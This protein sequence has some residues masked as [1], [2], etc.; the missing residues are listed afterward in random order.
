[1]KFNT[2]L[3]TPTIYF[4]NFLGIIPICLLKAKKIKSQK[5]I[6]P[7]L[8]LVLIISLIEIGI[9]IYFEIFSNIHYNSAYIF[10]IYTL[11]EFL[12]IYFYF[13]N[14][15]SS[16]YTIFFKV[17]AIFFLLLFAY[18]ILIWNIDEASKTDSYLSLVETFFVLITAFL[19]FKNNLENDHKVSLFDNP[20]FYYIFGFVFYFSTTIVLFLLT[21][22]L[23]NQGYEEFW[24]FYIF[25]IL[26]AILWRV[27]QIIGV[28]K[29]RVK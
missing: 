12:T 22:Y 18:F 15:L 13:K 23:Q 20:D 14:I 28:W 26:F 17:T 5:A 10:R 6:T 8:W 16:S 11:L 7:F 27:F 3:I 9:T 29:A 24:G 1:M 25:N 2:S 4:A 19:W 21:N